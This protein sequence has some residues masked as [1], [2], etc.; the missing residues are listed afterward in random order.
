[1]V[2]EA[3]PYADWEHECEESHDIEYHD[4]HVRCSID[5]QRMSLQKQESVVVR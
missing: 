4:R 1:M 2:K 5:N 3:Y